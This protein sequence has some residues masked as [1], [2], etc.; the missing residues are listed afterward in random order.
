MVPSGSSHLRL[1]GVMCLPLLLMAQSYFQQALR[2]LM[3]L[4]SFLDQSLERGTLATMFFPKALQR[5][6][7]KKEM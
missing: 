1:N 3:L 7:S 4:R 5:F 6:L 2:R